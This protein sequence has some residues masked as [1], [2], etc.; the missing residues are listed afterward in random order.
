MLISR[1]LHN[2]STP[3][4]DIPGP[5]GIHEMNV[6]VIAHAHPDESVGGAQGAAYNLFL[7]L[8]ELKENLRVTFVA[9][10]NRQDISSGSISYYRENEFLWKTN[11][12]DWLFLRNNNLDHSINKFI[13]LINVISPD[14]VFV[15]HFL[16]I[17]IEIFRV[18]KKERPSAKIVLTLHDFSAI[19]NRFGQMVKF[20]SNELCDVSS[21]SDCHSCFPHI[22]SDKFLERKIQIIRELELVDHFISPSNFLMKRFVDWGIPRLK[23]SVIE[24]G[25]DNHQNQN[26]VEY[27]SDRIPIVGFFG[28]F[29]P[30]KGADVLLRALSLFKSKLHGR[31]IVEFHAANVGQ[32]DQKFQEYLADL[33]LPLMKI[34]LVKWVGPYSKSQA[35]T[36]MSAVDWIV[37]PSIW[38]ENSPMV[39]QEAFGCGK[40]VIVSN[41]GGMAEKVQ[42]GVDGLHFKVGDP[43]DLGNCL[44]AIAENQKLQQH[45]SIGITPPP[46]LTE[47]ALAYI[48]VLSITD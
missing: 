26:S 17:G 21:P 22:S 27:N 43:Q 2:L 10:T 39:I 15:H 25:Q 20:P 31:L 3:A 37:V 7:G 29:T 44:L 9:R 14:V 42:H 48:N 46:T 41:I 47:T 24:N 23:F 12:Q 36:R 40:P 45:L 35:L 34:G 38:W 32:L 6:L 18:I 13:E 4:S 5:L 8:R 19:C 30:F 33:I 1:I 11:I 28:Q 16:N